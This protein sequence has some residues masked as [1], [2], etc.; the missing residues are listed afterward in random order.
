MP[1]K[2]VIFD[3]DGTLLDSLKG[4]G[5]AMNRL[6]ENRGFPVHP[7]ED[8]R[9]LV[10]DGMRELVLR[11]L[12]PQVKLEKAGL[13]EVEKE[14]REIYDQLWPLETIPYDGIPETLDRLSR[15]NIKLAVLSNKTDYCTRQMV[16]ELLGDWDFPVVFGKR[17]GVP[18]KPDPAAAL[19]IA[20]KLDTPPG[21]VVFVGDTSV[22]MQTAVNAGMYPIGVLWG[23]REAKELKESGAKVLI[24]QPLELPELIRK[25][26]RNLSFA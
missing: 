5:D 16:E 10:G 25:L 12:P 22:D 20:G 8:Y 21:Q 26:I 18:K 7:L 13:L 3:L 11:A 4:I 15:D 17:E 1:I 23:F 6:L 14:Y 9:Y 19:E 2:T 24:R